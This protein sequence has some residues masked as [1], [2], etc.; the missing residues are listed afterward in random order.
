MFH[1]FHHEIH[2]Q[3][4]QTAL[5]QLKQD[6]VNIPILCISSVATNAIQCNV[7]DLL[8]LQDPLIIKT[9]MNIPNVKLTKDSVYKNIGAKIEINQLIESIVKATDCIIVITESRVEAQSLSLKFESS[10]FYHAGLDKTQRQR[11]AGEFRSKQFN[12]LFTTEIYPE[13]VRDDVSYF[14]YQLKFKLEFNKY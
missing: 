2:R 9:D 6:F 5:Q 3:N 8:N 11:I 13:L 10:R 4:H 1:S 7:S 14:F 12:V